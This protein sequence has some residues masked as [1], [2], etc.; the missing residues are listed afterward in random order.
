MLENEENKMNTEN[1][2][3]EVKNLISMTGITF[4]RHS[5]P[6]LRVN[7]MGNYTAGIS[8]LSDYYTKIQGCQLYRAVR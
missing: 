4:S 5:L 8:E 7:H 6:D 1:N 3:S 2:E